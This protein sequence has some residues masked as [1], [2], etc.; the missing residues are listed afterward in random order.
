M[1]AVLL[2]GF[3]IACELLGDGD[4]ERGI[5]TLLAHPHE[6]PAATGLVG[7]LIQT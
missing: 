4:R 7:R 3:S 2:R 6:N 5:T 1:A